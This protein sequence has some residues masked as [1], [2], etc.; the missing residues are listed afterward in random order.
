MLCVAGNGAL[1]TLSEDGSTV[2]SSAALPGTPAATT[3]L[4]AAGEREQQSA[5]ETEVAGSAEA[6]DSRQEGEVEST[7]PEFLPDNGY[8]GPR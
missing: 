7:G 2:L 1:W 3:P 8:R 6:T 5:A 4:A